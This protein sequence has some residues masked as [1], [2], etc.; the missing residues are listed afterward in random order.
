MNGGQLLLKSDNVIVD[1]F[2]TESNGLMQKTLVLNEEVDFT[3]ISYDIKLFKISRKSPFGDGKL[4]V[5]AETLSYHIEI[6]NVNQPDVIYKHRLPVQQTS[7]SNVH[8][9]ST[10]VVDVF[11]LIDNALVDQLATSKDHDVSQHSAST[12]DNKAKSNMS[13]KKTASAMKNKDEDKNNNQNSK[14]K[15]KE[16]AEEQ[17]KQDALERK[18]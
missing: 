9:P 1:G 15:E 7:K 12:L 3:E 14:E 11:N 8:D 6:F 4:Q 13:N 16:A 5:G 2:D 17:K 18:A 10:F